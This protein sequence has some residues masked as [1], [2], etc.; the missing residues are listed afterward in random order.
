[1]SLGPRRPARRG[2]PPL[3]QPHWGASVLIPARHRDELA[4]AGRI[5]SIFQG[6]RELAYD[7][8]GM[9]PL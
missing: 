7:I 3:R 9:R 2:L 8:G 6:L 5:C 1:M 4:Q